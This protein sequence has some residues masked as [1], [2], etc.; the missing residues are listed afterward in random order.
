MCID[1]ACLFLEI[2]QHMEQ[3]G[4]LGNSFIKELGQQKKNWKTF[5]VGVLENRE[6][7][8]KTKKW[9]WDQYRIW[10]KGRKLSKQKKWLAVFVVMLHITRLYQ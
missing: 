2:Y 3:N 7:I 8:S 6:S 4:V 10:L 9:A 5:H 1:N